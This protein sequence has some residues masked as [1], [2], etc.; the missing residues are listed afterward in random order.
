MADHDTRVQPVRLRT[1]R[2]VRDHE[3][4][5]RASRRRD[6]EEDVDRHWGRLVSS[7]LEAE[8]TR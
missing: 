7:E 2:L 6:R 1:D 3:V 8:R 5:F 4:R